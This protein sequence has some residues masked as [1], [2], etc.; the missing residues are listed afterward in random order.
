MYNQDG[1]V[2]N[3][4]S[5]GGHESDVVNQIVSTLGYAGALSI[6]ELGPIGIGDSWDGENITRRVIEPETVPE[7]L[8]EDE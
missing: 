8:F 6:C 1:L 4:L 7:D 5:F 2:V 3:L